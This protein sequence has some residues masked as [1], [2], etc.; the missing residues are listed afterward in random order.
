MKEDFRP[1]DPEDDDKG[2]RILRLERRIAF[3]EGRRTGIKFIIE[4]TAV[5]ITLL[6]AAGIA[7]LWIN[8][9]NFQ[10]QTLQNVENELKQQAGTR[11]KEVADQVLTREQEILDGVNRNM[12]QMF[13]E[14]DGQLATRS[15]VMTAESAS[16]VTVLTIE[17]G[18][19]AAALSTSAASLLTEIEIDGN[20]Q[21]TEL[22]L[23]KEE[24][25]TAIFEA[26]SEQLDSEAIVNV[27]AESLNQKV[28][29]IFEQTLQQAVSATQEARRLEEAATATREAELAVTPTP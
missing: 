6:V 4:I 17:A 27:A 20:Q 22:E 26:V 19:R 14:F 24:M 15:L 11:E 3:E 9:R 12:E 5:V 29:E 18:T 16:R 28:D 25:A 1:Y 23:M 21:V 2:D 13:T 8:T 7:T 10:Q